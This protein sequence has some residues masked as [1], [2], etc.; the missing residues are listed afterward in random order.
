M[1]EN[2]MSDSQARNSLSNTPT[3]HVWSLIER[4]MEKQRCETIRHN[5]FFFCIILKKKVA[6]TKNKNKK[7]SSDKKKPSTSGIKKTNAKKAKPKG[8][9]PPASRGARKKKEQKGTSAVYIAVQHTLFFFLRLSRKKLRTRESSFVSFVV[10]FQRALNLR[11]RLA[12]DASLRVL[13]RFSREFR[14]SVRSTRNGRSHE[15]TN[16]RITASE[17]ARTL[18]TLFFIFFF[19]NSLTSFLSSH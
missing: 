6:M 1:N 2:G 18:E 12:L 13:E 16:A 14:S 10:R 9:K 19:K 17:N 15:R 5:F 11:Y 4:V 8:G 7:Q 3:H